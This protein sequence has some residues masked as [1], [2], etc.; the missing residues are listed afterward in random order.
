MSK[1][2]LLGMGAMGSRMAKALIEA[3]HTLHIYNVVGNACEPIVALGAKA[4]VTPREAAVGVDFVIAM[5]WDDAASAYVW[6]DPEIG[7]MQ[8]LSKGAVAIECAT[9]TVEHE[10]RL[11]KA[12]EAQDVEFVSAPMSGSLPEADAKTLIFTTGASKQAFSKVEPILMAMGQ[13]I[14]HAGD[15]LDGISLKLLINSKLALEYAAMAEMIA[16]LLASGKDAKRYLEIAASTAPFSARGVREARYMLDGNE[17]SRVK[18][19]QL[20]KDSANHIAQCKTHGVPCHMTEAANLV[21]RKAS[22]AG[23]GD[24]DAVALARIYREQT[25]Q[26]QAA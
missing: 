16:F 19:N 18:I 13:K 3:K 12:A 17:T 4:F 9:L 20:I 7:A 2:A 5:V 10:A 14:N 22:A 21:F 1:I 15:P 24:L 23:F 6:L 26:Y 25:A 11:M 8:S